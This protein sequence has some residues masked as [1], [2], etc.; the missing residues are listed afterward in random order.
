MIYA[1]NANEILQMAIDVEENGLVFYELAQEKVE[2]PEVKDIFRFLAGEERAHKKQFESLKAAL[3]ES[4]KAET[5]WDPNDQ[6]VQYLQM[7]ADLHVFGK[8]GVSEKYL[9]HVKSTEDA[10]NMAIQFE[11][12]SIIFFLSLEEA[13]EDRQARLKVMDLINEERQHIKKLALKLR[14]LRR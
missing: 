4:A 11:K 13:V 1:F 2:E 7:M 8:A 14:Q 3:P 5:V 6:M 10:L 12:D 9:E